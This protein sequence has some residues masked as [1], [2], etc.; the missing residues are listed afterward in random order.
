MS[1]YSFPMRKPA[2]PH[3]LS[4]ILQ[5]S[6]GSEKNSSSFIHYQLWNRWEEIVG[7]SLAKNTQPDKWR[8]RVLIIR[9]KNSSWVQELGFMKQE[10]LQKIRNAIPQIP[11]DE[12]RF[13]IGKLQIYQKRKPRKKLAQREVSGDELK[14]IEEVCMEIEDQELQEQIQRLMRKHFQSRP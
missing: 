2:R 6:L 3:K 13:E 14:F 5:V 9:T 4:D 1:T 8:G 10:L 7:T 12:L 11:C